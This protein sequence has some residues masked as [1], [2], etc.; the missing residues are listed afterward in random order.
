VQQF[1]VDFEGNIEEDEEEAPAAHAADP[2]AGA[3]GSPRA[4]AHAQ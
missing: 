2:D 4:Q 3:A 1:R